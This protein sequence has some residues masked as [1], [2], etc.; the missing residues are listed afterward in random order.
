MPGKYN[1]FL[2]T[3]NSISSPNPLQLE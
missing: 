1:N 3:A 2:P